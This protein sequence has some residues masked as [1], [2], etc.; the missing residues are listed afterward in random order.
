MKN[1]EFPKKE[2]GC[3]II[4]SPWRR[5]LLAA[6]CYAHRDGYKSPFALKRILHWREQGEAKE[7]R[8]GPNGEQPSLHRRG[9]CLENGA[10]PN[11]LATVAY[12]RLASAPVKRAAIRILHNA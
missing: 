4:A 2:P 8:P 10:L 3:R 11:E 5:I 12:V 9:Q 1:Q 7:H 6:R